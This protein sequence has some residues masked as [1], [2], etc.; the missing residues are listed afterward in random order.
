MLLFAN[1]VDKA[2][3]HPEV[4]FDAI[5]KRMILVIRDARCTGFISLSPE[6]GTCG[7]GL[8]GIKEVRKYQVILPHRPN[9]P[10]LVAGMAPHI[11]AFHD[12][13]ALSDV[14]ALFLELLFE[15]YPADPEY[16]PE[17][18]DRLRTLLAGPWIIDPA[19]ERIQW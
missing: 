5:T 7:C 10:V 1:S 6:T 19:T 15:L 2:V 11:V 3:A 17:E 18:E 4:C 12:R 16:S 9:I 14:E 8:E 13:D